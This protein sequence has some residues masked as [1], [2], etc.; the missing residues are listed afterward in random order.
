[1]VGMVNIMPVAFTFPNL[2]NTHFQWLYYVCIW[3][4]YTIN[5]CFCVTTLVDP[6]KLQKIQSPV[7]NLDY[8]DRAAQVKF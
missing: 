7:P 3:T 2:S 6:P 4:S 8:V 1:M 5:K